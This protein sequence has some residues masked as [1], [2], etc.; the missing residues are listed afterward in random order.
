MKKKISVVI[1]ICMAICITA[2]LGYSYG[3]SNGK[4]ELPVYESMAIYPEFSMPEL[5]ERASTIVSAT[6]VNIGDTYIEE[7][8]V[9]VTENPNEVSEVLYNPITPI[10]LEVESSLKGNVTMNTITYYEEGGITSTYIQLPDGYTMEEGMEVILFL[11]EEGYSWG[12][13]S[14]F[15]IVDNEV[16]LNKM[17]LEYLDDSEVLVINTSQ[18]ENN[19]RS[20]ITDST[21]SVI[22]KEEFLS[23]IEE[24]V[25]K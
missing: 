23:I 9:S 13:Q 5:T 25:N 21:V 19:V 22:D 1:I 8:P 18:I 16:I 24:I 11:N 10:T 6:V 3:K 20:Q 7:I 15:P 2:I 4:T 17:A 14:I 12:A